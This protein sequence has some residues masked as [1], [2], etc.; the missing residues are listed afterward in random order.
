MGKSMLESTKTNSILRG[1]LSVG[2][3]LSAGVLGVASIALR[4]GMR[5]LSV[6]YRK[7]SIAIRKPLSEFDISRLPSFKNGW[8]RSDIPPDDIETDEYAIIRLSAEQKTTIPRE[9][10]LFVTYYSDPNSK[11]PHTPD[12]CSRQGGAILRD[13]RSITIDIPVLLRSTV[14]ARLLLAQY[15][16]YDEAIIFCFYADGRFRNSREQ[17]RWDIGMPGNRHVYFSKI[18]TVARYPT[19]ESPDAAIELCKKLFAEAAPVLISDHFPT[20]EQVRR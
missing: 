13:M 17:V 11:V 15:Q 19:D 10:V 18:E 16:G 1:F 4:P 3:L 14:K 12:V 7:E 8:V 9:V 20:P 5:A 6:Y 2:F